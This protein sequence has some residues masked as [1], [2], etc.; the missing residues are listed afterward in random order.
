[1]N[2]ASNMSINIKVTNDEF[3]T[4]YGKSQFCRDLSYASVM[5]VLDYIDTWSEDGDEVV[6]WTEYFMY[7]HE[8]T[9]EELIR[10][11]KYILDKTTIENLKD[12]PEA[13]LEELIPYMDM[14]V[15]CAYNANKNLYVV[16]DNGE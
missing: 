14:T 2:K 16:I 6:D 3:Y 9:A 11:F 15:L 8:Y 1:M 7:A 12:D 10:D 4:L 13:L 5:E